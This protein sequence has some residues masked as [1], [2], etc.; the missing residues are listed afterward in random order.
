MKRVEKVKEPEA[1][2]SWQ[3]RGPTSMRGEEQS[4]CGYDDVISREREEE[5]TEEEEEDFEAMGRFEVPPL[6]LISYFNIASATI[7]FVGI[8]SFDASF[9]GPSS[10]SMVS[11]VAS[12]VS[13][14]FISAKFSPSCP[15]FS[16]MGEV[17][18]E[19]LTAERLVDVSERVSQ[20]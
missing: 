10:V 1:A 11:D 19:L 9:G 3:G 5:T 7:F 15:I 6:V 16:S 4:P 17:W 13:C 14:W 12:I 2:S 8:S 20:P 18:L